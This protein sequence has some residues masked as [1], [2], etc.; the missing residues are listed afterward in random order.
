ML[1]L[2]EGSYFDSKHDDKEWDFGLPYVHIN[3]TTRGEIAT[4][5][6]I[7]VTLDVGVLESAVLKPSSERWSGPTC[8]HIYV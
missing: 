5:N 3:P 1:K 8:V 7:S 2:P 6:G 4:K